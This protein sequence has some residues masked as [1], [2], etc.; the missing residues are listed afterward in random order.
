MPREPRFCTPRPPF[1]CS[2]WGHL[3]VRVGTCPM[4]AAAVAGLLASSGDSSGPLPGAPRRVCRQTRWAPGGTDKWVAGSDRPKTR[5]G[6]DL[7]LNPTPD[8]FMHTERWS[9][10]LC[11]LSPWVVLVVQSKYLWVTPPTVQRVTQ[12]LGP[13]CKTWR[14]VGVQSIFFESVSHDAK[15]GSFTASL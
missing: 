13:P 14:T 10:S 15:F 4:V 9:S 6:K 1:L 5:P 8:L 12:N 3:S 11:F 7:L 2:C